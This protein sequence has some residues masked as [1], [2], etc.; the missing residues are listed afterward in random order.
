MRLGT[1]GS[2]RKIKG[3]ED[4]YGLYSMDVDYR[5][6]L[7]RLI[8]RGITDDLSL[9]D[10]I[11]KEA[12]PLIPVKFRAPQFGCTAFSIATCDSKHYM[13]RNYDFKLDTSAMLV[14][15][16]PKGGYA[17]IAF[18]ALD[19]IGAND[20]LP[21]RSRAACL[22]A[23][24]ICLDGVNEKGVSI[25]VLTLDSEPTRQK[26]DGRPTIATTL[27]I[28]LVLDRAD[29]TESAVKLIGSYSM[30]ASSGRDYHFF[31]TDAAGDSRVVE[32]DCDSPDRKMTVTSAEATTNFYA[33]YADRVAPNRRNGHYGHGKERYEAVMD[34]IERTRGSSSVGDVWEAL[35]ASSQLPNPEDITSNTQ[36]SIAFSNT[37]LTADITLRLHWEDRFMCD[38]RTGTVSEARIPEKE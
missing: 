5:Y 37:D 26:A 35:R 24:F 1:M 19:N 27:V 16:H 12:L 15:C 10:A 20:P 30:M 25:A 17:S 36:W 3:Y 6:D 28:R 29:S 32:F 34:V 4:G 8:S 31:I 13:G 18:A 21:F 9:A 33:M 7:D 2:I 14:R 11:R 22:A 38:L 23:P